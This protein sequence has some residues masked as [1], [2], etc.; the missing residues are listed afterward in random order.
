M[1]N[2]KS[3]PH[4]HPSPYSGVNKIRNFPMSCKNSNK[5]NNNNN[6]NNNNINSEENCIDYNTLKNI[7]CSIGSDGS[8][9]GSIYTLKKQKK[10]A[11][12]QLYRI[13]NLS[14]IEIM[15][16]NQFMKCCEIE[17]NTQIQDFK[18]DLTTN[19][20]PSTVSLLALHSSPLIFNTQA[21]NYDFNEL[22]LI[23]YGGQG[24]LVRINLFHQSYLHPR[25]QIFQNYKFH[26]SEFIN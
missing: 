19:I 17:I 23:G 16:N 15:E 26:D 20:S 10:T 4:S 11:V 12:T 9:I 24:G 14:M 2:S 1:L 3:I 13:N 6:N 25:I 18:P 22:H 8:L 7:I 21:N 5:N